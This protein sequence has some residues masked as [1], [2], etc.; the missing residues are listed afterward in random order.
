MSST[1][2]R[3]RRPGDS[4]TRD[5][6]LAAARTRFAAHGYDR[7]RIRDVA[8]DAG[9][10][11]ALVHYFFKT[12]EGLFAAALALPIRPAEIIPPLVAPGVSGLGERLLRRVL[13][14]WDDP[15]YRDALLAMLHGASTMPGA[16]DAIREFV[17][18]ELRGR[19]IEVIEAGEPELRASLAGSQIVGL[20]ILRYVVRAEPLASLPREAVVPLVAPTLQRYLD[21]PLTPDEVASRSAPT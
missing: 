4:S 7:T 8:G 12:K 5:A 11:P 19:V 3:G 16:L 2:R 18:V 1:R 20:V 13:E 6:I 10:D 21:G 9:V 15:A 17:L 14:I